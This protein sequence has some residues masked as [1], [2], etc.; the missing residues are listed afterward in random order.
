MKRILLAGGS[1]FV[2]SALKNFLTQQGD[3]V[4]VLSRKK[5]KNTIFWD[6]VKNEI[7]PHALEN[8]DFLICLAGANI[9][10]KRWTAAYQKEILDSRI[11][12][13]Q[14]LEKALL[15]QKHQIKKCIFV[16][17]SG[18]YGDQKD[19][20][21][22]EKNPAGKGFLAEVCQKWE[23]AYQN[24]PVPC[25]G[26]RLGVVMG[27]NGGILERLLQPLYLGFCPI[28]GDGKQFL[29]WI[30]LRDLCR[31]FGFFLQNEKTG[32]FNVC[33]PEQLSLKEILLQL[34]K[35]IFPFALVF[36]LP[37]FVLRFIFGQQSHLFLDSQ[38]MSCEKLQEA[39]FGFEYETIQKIL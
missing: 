30:D 5:N 18:Y 31:I 14:L 24:F 7:D 19:Q 17:G 12:S 6:P 4:F 33:T 32:I 15:S 1:G 21:L 28:L 16:S 9:G 29:S 22:T 35:K 2:G 10:Q 3:Q 27:K 13:A 38:R 20:I 37:V 34:R 39:G 36:H 23:V 26:L 11:Q 8:I 25:V